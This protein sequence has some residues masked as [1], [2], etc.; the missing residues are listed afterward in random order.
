VSYLALTDR[1]LLARLVGDEEAGRLLDAHGSLYGIAQASDRASSYL[2]GVPQGVAVAIECGRRALSLPAEQVESWTD[3]ETAWEHY[4]G[5]IAGLDR[6]VLYAIGL[7]VRLRRVCEVTLADG[8]MSRAIV[9]PRDVF[10]PL[11]RAGA[12]SCL[13]VHNHPSGDP[14]PSAD[15]RRLTS[16]IAMAGQL[17]GVQVVDHVIVTVKAYHSFAADGPLG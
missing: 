3:A 11:L 7:D 9:D 13:L 12:A 4:R 1:E 5:R 6:E 17:V 8:G 14:S 15:D 10:V 16:R 2:V